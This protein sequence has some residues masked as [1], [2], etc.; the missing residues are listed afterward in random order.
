[1][2]AH[3]SGQLMPLVGQVEL[4]VHG[5]KW[6]VFN[7]LTHEVLELVGLAADDDELFLRRA[8]L[9]LLGL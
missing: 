2:A 7:S 3:S 4:S 9:W 8:V 6:V 1:M 5:S